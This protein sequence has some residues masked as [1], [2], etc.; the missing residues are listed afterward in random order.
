MKRGLD[1]VHGFPHP[2]RS[3]GAYPS[4][5]PVPILLKFHLSALF[6]L[7]SGYAVVI[8]FHKETSVLRDDKHNEGS[9]SDPVPSDKEN[10]GRHKRPVLL[11]PGP[12]GGL[13]GSSAADHS[14]SAVND[15]RKDRTLP[16]D[17]VQGPSEEG[18]GLGDPGT[19]SPVPLRDLCSNATVLPV[20][21]PLIL[22]LPVIGRPLAS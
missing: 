8:L 16:G 5:L 13:L 20:H 12:R 18:S 17:P 9:Q 22:L 15:E 6:L 1:R 3:Q 2:A 10:P 7:L 21:L 11:L 4:I 19:G 14:Q